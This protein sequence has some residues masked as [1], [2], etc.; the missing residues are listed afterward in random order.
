MSKFSINIALFLFNV[1][2]IEVDVYALHSLNMTH[3]FIKMVCK[4]Q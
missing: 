4:I 3:I 1:P 2:W